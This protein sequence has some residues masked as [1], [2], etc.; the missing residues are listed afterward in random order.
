MV[1]TVLPNYSFR[2]LRYLLNIMIRLLT[3]CSPLFALLIVSGCSGL[4]NSSVPS[5]TKYV[6]TYT[7]EQPA[8]NDDL[9]FR[10]DNIEISFVFDA[11]AITF[12]LYNMSEQQISIAWERVS[13]GVNKR[14][15]PVRNN[16]TFYTM[17][18]ATPQPLGVPPQGF[19]R[20][21]VIPWQ[22]VNY[23]KGKW[24][25]QELFPTND[26]GSITIREIIETTAGSEITLT[27]PIRIGKLVMDYTFIF[28]VDAA[29]PL[30]FGVMPPVNE[31]PPK[32][33][34]PMYELSIMQGYLPI[35]ISAGI[36]IISIIIFSQKKAPT[37]GL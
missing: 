24:I 31:R 4:M 10:D 29:T 32:P 20:E 33:D 23:E 34:A 14:M 1:F 19:L 26:S 5:G 2:I 16:T 36:L 8:Q 11:S 25:E 27:L 21:T 30:P 13:L 18:H 15:Y 22:H 17:G 6:Y 3:H 7:M 35:I 37:E 9:K 28:K 12:Q